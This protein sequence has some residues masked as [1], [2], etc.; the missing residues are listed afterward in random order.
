[1]VTFDKMS[2]EQEGQTITRGP[3]ESIEAALA[4]VGDRWSLLILREAFHGVRRYEQMLRNLGV[5]RAVLASRLRDLT[6]AGLL[7]AVPY[8]EGTARARH[9]YR[10]TRPG[11]EL[12][13]ALVALMEWAERNVEGAAGT[14]DVLIHRDCG[15]RVH[16]ALNCE[17]GHD[18][19]EPDEIDPIRADRSLDPR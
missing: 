5:S 1:M 19:V 15:A 14:A 17:G 7:R 11:V 18:A 10:P 13:T 16:A 12:L 8:R 2:A 3:V 9:E 6:A 4:V